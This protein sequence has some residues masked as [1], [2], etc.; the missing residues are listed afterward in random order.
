MVAVVVVRL[1]LITPI[2][3]EAYEKDRAEFAEKLLQE[4]K[5]NAFQKWFNDLKEKS[6]LK[7]SL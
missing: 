3:D 2:N 5:N 1:D 4:K 7:D 6:N